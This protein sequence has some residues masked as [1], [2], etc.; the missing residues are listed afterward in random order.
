MAKKESKGYGGIIYK[1]KKFY[2]VKELVLQLQEDKVIEV[3]PGLI[4]YVR[5]GDEMTF[6]E[7]RDY[8]RKKGLLGLK[9]S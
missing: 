7:F 8:L 2:T 1:G 3:L 6:G 5:K 4:P 9:F